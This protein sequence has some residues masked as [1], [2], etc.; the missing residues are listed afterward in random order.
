M[1]KK[2]LIVADDFTG[3]NDTG[4][5]LSKRD[6]R[7]IVTTSINAVNEMILNNDALVI[8]TESRFDLSK[9]AYYKTYKIGK[10][11]KELIEQIDVYNKIDSTF[12]GNIGAEISGLIDGTG[13]ETVFLAPALP[14][15]GRTIKNGE[16]FVNGKSILCTE[17]A[18]D[19]KTPVKFN[20]ISDIINIQTDKKVGNV[21]LECIRS[22]VE[23]LKN[24][25]NELIKSFCQI[26]VFDSE[27]NEDLEIIAQVLKSLNINSIYSGSAGFAS[28]LSKY[29][30]KKEVNAQLILTVAGSVSN[31]TRRQ[32]D[33][34]IDNSSVEVINLNY[35][36]IFANPE[37]E[38]FSLMTHLKNNHQSTC[39]I[40][41]RST[42]SKEDVQKAFDAAEI[43]GVSEESASEKILKFLSVLAKLIIEEYKI[44]GL[45]LT[46]GDTAIHIIDELNIRGFSIINEI[47]AGIPYGNFVSENYNNIF[48]ATKAGGFG[49]DISIYEAIKFL[50]GL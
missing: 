33:Y 39:D 50:K 11:L 27:N 37:N 42:Q 14:D 49:N 15:A 32:L 24:R 45:F 6:I 38:L 29:Y 35:Q 46:G 21:Y 18:S 5:Q 8:D 10:N 43:E 34:V 47:Q 2:L 7:T 20:S 9:E 22:G 17:Y 40:I 48:V 12:R 19:P 28:A 25:I 44:K 26:I 1:N 30:V 23:D 31:V 13:I 4:V 36:N 3:S 41:I 16:I